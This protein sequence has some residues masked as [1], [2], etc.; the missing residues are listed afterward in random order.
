MLDVF[1]MAPLNQKSSINYEY[2]S[3]NPKVRISAAD[4]E[5]EHVED[6][7]SHFETLLYHDIATDVNFYSV[8]SG[9]ANNT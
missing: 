6:T 8:T 4:T 3:P 7:W 1:K 2:P 9:T 5:L